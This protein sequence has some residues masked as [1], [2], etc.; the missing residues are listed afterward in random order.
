VRPQ[1]VFRSS[2]RTPLIFGRGRS[3]SSL[4]R[5]LLR[6]ESR[7]WFGGVAEVFD[8]IEAFL[9]AQDVLIIDGWQLVFFF[10]EPYFVPILDDGLGSGH[11][12]FTGV[13][14]LREGA[15]KRRS[16]L[17][18]FLRLVRIESFLEGQILQ[19][20]GRFDFAMKA[21][22]MGGISLTHKH[23]LFLTNIYL[24]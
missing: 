10:L 6:L 12:M 14:G 16:Q 13:V 3:D 2:A 9:E 8:A 11:G 24:L 5:H 22:G 1:R 17:A 19:D 18:G 20:I 15:L 4:A 7:G 23:L 21:A